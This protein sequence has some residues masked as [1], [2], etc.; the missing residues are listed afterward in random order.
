MNV[1]KEEKSTFDKIEKIGHG[2]LVQHGKLNDR[3]Y[4][5]KLHANDRESITDMI[6][7][8]AAESNYSKIF[9]KVPFSARNKFI[10]DGYVQ[11]AVIPRYYLNAEDVWFMAKYLSKDRSIPDFVDLKNF[12]KVLDSPLNSL[13]YNVDSEVTLREL[14]ESDVH[15][16]VDIYNKVFE[17]YPFPIHDPNYIKDVMKSHVRF[18]GAFFHDRLIGLSSAE[19]DRVAGA[20]EMTDFAVL[21]ESRGKRLAYHLLNLMEK[22]M[23]AEGIE[24]VFTIARIKSA[25]MNKTFINSGYSFS[26]TL[27]NNTNI[28]G[29]IESMNVY[30]KKLLV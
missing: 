30:Y 9:V 7:T 26:G 11:E 17:T 19:I 16:I 15:R 6:G 27:V 18:F 1:I 23:L 24:T 3:L 5:I 21:P 14:N 20:A 12:R 25:A 28:S 2:S 22:E 13:K 29:N 10:R 4:L 8:I